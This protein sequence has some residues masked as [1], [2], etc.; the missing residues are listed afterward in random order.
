[1][2]VGSRLVS[3]RSKK[4]LVVARLSSE[5]EYRVSSNGSWRMRIVVAKNFL[6]RARFSFKDFL[7]L[8][9]DNT[10]VHHISKNVVHHEC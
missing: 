2:L 6:V 3:W 10:T 8:H 5:A 4:Q 7:M 9:R 1:M